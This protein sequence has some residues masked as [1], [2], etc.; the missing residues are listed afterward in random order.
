MTHHSHTNTS[1]H[2]NSQ[3]T[4]LLRYTLENHVLFLD[5]SDGNGTRQLHTRASRPLLEHVAG[6]NRQLGSVAIER[7]A[8]HARC[9]TT[10]EARTRSPLREVRQPLLGDSVPD[11]HRPIGA[12]RGEGAV[13]TRE[14]AALLPHGMHR[15]GVHG[16]DHFRAEGVGLP[17]AAEGEGLVRRR[18]GE[19][20]DAR[21][22]LDAAHDVSRAVQQ[23]AN[24]AEVELEQRLAQNGRRCQRVEVAHCD[25]AVLKGNE[26]IAIREREN[27]DAPIP[28]NVHRVHLSGKR[29]HVKRGILRLGVDVPYLHRI[30]PAAAHNP[31]Y[32]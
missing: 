12:A 8:H 15:D 20:L 19:E 29:V 21:S 13:S 1:T 30:V 10:R 23:R 31:I 18:L 3:Q 25:L 27:A 17:V 6:G 9:V 26:K 22:A 7:Q 4:Q 28:R 32:G 11:A 24:A 14:L 16:V 2:L 5:R